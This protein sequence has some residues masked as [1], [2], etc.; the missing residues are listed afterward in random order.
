VTSGQ[1]PISLYINTLKYLKP[2]QVYH[3]LLRKAFNYWYRPKHGLAPVHFCDFKFLSHVTPDSVSSTNMENLLTTAEQLMNNEFVF[4]NEN[5]WKFE[6]GIE[7]GADPYEYRLWCFNLNYFDY[8]ATLRRAYLCTREPRFLDKGIDMIR[9]W[10]AFSTNS[11]SGAVWNPFVASKRLVNWLVFLQFVRSCRKFEMPAPISSSLHTHVDFVRRNI[12]FHLKANHVIMNAKALVFGG[13]AIGDGS[14]LRAGVRLLRKEFEE[15]ILADGGHYERSPSYHVE[16]LTHFLECARLL[17]LNGHSELGRALYKDLRIMFDFLHQ[18]MMPNEEIPLLND[19][20]L[21]YPFSARD[22]LDCGVI[23]FKDGK[24]KREDDSRLGWY[25]C[26]LFG[27]KGIEIYN[28]TRKRKVRSDTKLSIGES[29]YCIIRDSI[30]DRDIYFLFDCGDCGPDYNPGHG[31]ADSLSVLLTLGS[32]KILT[33]SGTFTY[34]QSDA[35]NY[36]RSTHAHNTISIDNKSSSEV[37]SAFRVAKRAKT[38][39]LGRCETSDTVLVSAEHDGYCKVLPHDRLL[40]RRTVFYVKGCTFVIFDTIHGHIRRKHLLESRYVFGTDKV[41]ACN[42]DLIRF[43]ECGL[44]LQTQIPARRAEFH[45]SEYFGVKRTVPGVISQIWIDRPTTMYTVIS[46]SR[47]VFPEV[48]ILTPYTAKVGL[49]GRDYTI[50]LRAVKL[51]SD[52]GAL[53]Q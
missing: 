5:T 48:S 37:W 1:Y 8:L 27:R 52:D 2:S 15:Q 44:T 19:S 30:K 29:G 34:K 25:G 35:R 16:V 18:I 9:E 17:E 41:S 24:Y 22:V 51:K 50:D 43:Y 21:D 46:L 20:S 49:F 39:L 4:L 42:R 33:D 28:A 13:L 26:E 12:E 23:V 53:I 40:H 45:I 3:R 14:A 31:H 38:T 47:D 11:R 6:G 36:F 7:W 10:I 32:H